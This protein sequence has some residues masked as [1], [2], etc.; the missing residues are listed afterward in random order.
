MY[1]IIKEW[2]GLCLLIVSFYYIIEILVG[3]V[4]FF[5][6]FDVLGMIYGDW[7]CKLVLMGEV[8]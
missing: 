4:R 2:Y 7:G 6:V 1:W 3:R 8:F 5:F